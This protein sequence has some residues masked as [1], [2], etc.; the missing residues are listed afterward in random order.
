MTRKHFAT[1]HPWTPE[2]LDKVASLYNANIRLKE[3]ARTLGYKH[4]G[5]LGSVLTELRA[6]GKIGMRN[7]K[8]A[9]NNFRL[10]KG[11]TQPQLALWNLLE[12]PAPAPTPVVSEPEPVT[13][14]APST[15]LDDMLAKLRR[16][17]AD[18]LQMYTDLKT[19][20]EALDEAIEKLE[21]A[22]EALGDAYR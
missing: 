14:N 13:T 20:M 7:A 21:D 1:R 16:E 2:F 19:K 5:S 11:E 18:W 12:M 15:P 3:I 9:G 4:G 6:Q 8:L 10:G 22:K 17:K